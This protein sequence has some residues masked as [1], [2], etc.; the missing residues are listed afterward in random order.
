MK[1]KI[2]KVNAED[3]SLE[4]L[5]QIQNNQIVVSSRQ[6]AENFGKEHGKVLRSIESIIK[7]SGK[8]EMACEIFLKISYENRGKQY[9]EYLMN[10]DGFSL[11]VMGFNGKKALEWK[12]KYIEAFNKMEAK[13]K[14]DIITLPDF[15]NPGEAA[16]AWA[17]QYDQKVAALEQVKQL[18]QKVEEESEF[19]RTAFDVE[20][21]FSFTATAKIISEKISH[22]GPRKFINYLRENNIVDKN[23]L[24]L[25]TYVKRGHM[26]IKEN[27]IR[28]SGKN[29]IKLQGVFT[30][31]GIDWI[32]RRLKREKCSL[33]IS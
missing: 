14:Q 1:N 26:K 9:P 3:I 12:L 6:V 24:P 30:Q 10:R 2:T 33:I 18:E 31:K 11:L 8:P 27:L 21:C 22:I 17:D 28:N 4:E 25:S 19:R 15:T 23:D 29:F 5:V 7:E 13:L 20:N 32:L 16:R